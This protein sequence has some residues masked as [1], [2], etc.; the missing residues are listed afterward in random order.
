VVAVG[1]EGVRS[2]WE[3]GIGRADDDATVLWQAATTH[4]PDP[5]S[6]RY[7]EGRCEV[8]VQAAIGGP[9]FRGRPYVDI[10]W[11]EGLR[12]S[13]MRLSPDEARRIAAMFGEAADR[14]EAVGEGGGSPP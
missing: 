6:L 5:Q 8:I 13:Y 7:G 1:E 12:P 4:T 9:V 10:Y 3:D 11:H 14:A 2:I